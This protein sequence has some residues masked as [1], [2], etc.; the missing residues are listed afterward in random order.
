VFKKNVGERKEQQSQSILLSLLLLSVNCQMKRLL[1]LLFLHLMVNQAWAQSYQAKNAM[2]TRVIPVPDAAV[3]KFNKEHPK[4]QIDSCYVYGNDENP[5]REFMFY[6]RQESIPF[7][8]S[9]DKRGRPIASKVEVSVKDLPEPLQKILT[10]N[11]VQA[12]GVG[13]AYKKVMWLAKRK[14]L[15]ASNGRKMKKKLPRRAKVEYMVEFI[16]DYNGKKLKVPMYFNES[17]YQANPG[18]R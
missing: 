18:F 16:A 5:E 6:A 8:A 1:G 12:E 2:R 15:P 10:N 17:G 13:K 4:S 3:R 7:E 14:R 9:Y 11:D